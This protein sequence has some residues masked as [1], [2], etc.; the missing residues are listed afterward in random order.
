MGNQVQDFNPGDRCSCPMQVVFLMRVGVALLGVPA[1]R[2]GASRCSYWGDQRW[3]P[4]EKLHFNLTHTHSLPLTL[5]SFFWFPKP[6]PPVVVLI[7]WLEKWEYCRN[8]H[9]KM[10]NLSYD[11]QKIRIH[12]KRTFREHYMIEKGRNVQHYPLYSTVYWLGK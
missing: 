12:C 6:K 2:T 7:H 10:H 8:M 4:M 9:K 1:A 3:F 11:I 5:T